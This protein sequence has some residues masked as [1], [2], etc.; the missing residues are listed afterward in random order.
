METII[1]SDCRAAAVAFVQSFPKSR[2]VEGNEKKI[3]V[4]PSVLPIY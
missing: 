2:K 3:S 4:V 1:H